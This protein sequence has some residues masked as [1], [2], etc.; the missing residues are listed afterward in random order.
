MFKNDIR[1]L[2]EVQLRTSAFPEILVNYFLL[3]DLTGPDLPK[4][5]LRFRAC[6]S[7]KGCETTVSGLQISF[8]HP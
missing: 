3:G 5:I 8:L 2:Y 1:H 6:G 4:S 7:P